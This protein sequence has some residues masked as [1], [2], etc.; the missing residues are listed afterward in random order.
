MIL[1]TLLVTYWSEPTITTQLILATAIGWHTNVYGEWKAWKA[2]LNTERWSVVI[3]VPILYTIIVVQHAMRA[4]S[5]SGQTRRRK[6]LMVV[7]VWSAVN[8]AVNHAATGLGDWIERVCQPTSPDSIRRNAIKRTLYKRQSRATTLFA[9]SVLAMQTRTTIASEREVRFDTDSTNV[10]VDNRCT[11]CISHDIG[12]FV[13]DSI[14]PSNRAIKGFGG[15]RVTNVKVG[16]LRWK[17][18]DDQ[19][20]ITEFLIPNSYLV[21]DGKVR[22]LSPQHWAQTQATKRSDRDK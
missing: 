9:L 10:G 5:D 7:R 12:D 17:W 13:P 2:A 19:G 18:E 6:W 3:Y 15:T 21:P 20:V 1:L 8:H 14:R 4:R 22:L 11:A 16:T